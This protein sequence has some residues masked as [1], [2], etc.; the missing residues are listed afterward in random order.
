MVAAFGVL[1]AAQAPTK[2]DPA[3]LKEFLT[4]L[5]ELGLPETAGAKWVQASF[6]DMAAP[7][8]LPSPEGR[9]GKGGN[10]W[11]VREEADG[12]V[13]LIVNQARRVRAVKSAGNVPS[14]G[15]KV[16]TIAE[17]N[18]EADLAA[19]EA[20]L[21][22]PEHRAPVDPSD[23][24]ARGGYEASARI[25]AAS[26]GLLLLAHLQR[27]GKAEQIA[28]LLPKL[29]ETHAAPE[30]VLDGAISTLAE[31]Q[32][33]ALNDAWVA[34]KTPD[35]Y[36][37]GLEALA[38]KFHRGWP[39][40]EGVLLLARRVREVRP[41]AAKSDAA[42]LL[43]SLTAEEVEALPRVENWLLP[44]DDP[45]AAAHLTFRGRHGFR[46]GPPQ[47]ATPEESPADARLAPF[48]ARK[49]EAASALA[50]L[51]A[52]GRY[53]RVLRP[54]ESAGPRFYSHND[55]PEEQARDCYDKMARP[56]E[57]AELVREVLTPVL[58][59]PLL[60]QD[61]LGKVEPQPAREWLKSLA[62]KS[63]EEIAWAYVGN[64]DA[65]D[66]TFL[67]A[68]AFLAGHSAEPALPRV[69]EI[70][71]DDAVWESND[72]EALA[73]IAKKL[74][75]RLGGEGAAFTGQ[76]LA[77]LEAIY[78]EK[79]KEG[80]PDDAESQKYAVAAARRQWKAIEQQ[81]RPRSLAELAAEIAAAPEEELGSTAQTLEQA[82][83][84]ATPE[85][86]ERAIYAAAAV[87]KSAAAKQHLLMAL[88]S[89]MSVSADS[90]RASAALPPFEP[91]T[92]AA[93]R[94]LLQ[95][96]SPLHLD[97]YSTERIVVQ[98]FATATVLAV[99]LSGPAE[100]DFY[101]LV[102]RA[103]R[104]AEAWGKRAVEALITGE[105]LPPLPT[106]ANIP[107]TQTTALR[108]RLA[109]LPAAQVLGAFESEPP[110]HQLALIDELAATQ[111][112]EQA[113]IDVQM[114]VREVVVPEGAPPELAKEKLLGRKVDAALR[115]A[116]AAAVI[117]AG[118]RKENWS[119]SASCPHPLAGV[120][121]TIQQPSGSSDERGITPDA[122]GL[123]AMP[124]P[125]ALVETTVQRR[126]ERGIARVHA[127][128]PIWTDP[129]LNDKW[130]EAHPGVLAAVEGK[131]AEFSGEP[132]ETAP[133]AQDNPAAVREF[134]AKLDRAEPAIVKGFAVIYTSSRAEK[135][136]AALEP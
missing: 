5:V 115:K 40:R 76:L 12:T 51:L 63:D 114:T 56:Y 4:L 108:Q 49:V 78:K 126:L 39:E 20:A 18:L 26:R 106:G 24:F 37:A 101:Q 80:D 38:Q 62:G 99:R 103:K 96:D 118:L 42:A 74:A 83:Q 86:A 2:A 8:G 85:E 89:R 81:L 14:R 71:L 29:M 35:T 109:A 46:G 79:E 61:D 110:A 92:R 53:L 84:Q 127:P 82:M 91:P 75:S 87:A 10:A 27:Q 72:V 57:L 28:R 113:F 135:P 77:K 124:P 122:R 68:L 33:A 69:R 48:F 102:F 44:L 90:S 25:L 45:D 70:L 3:A 129:A 133:N 94:A 121:V 131:G 125:D 47:R 50:E 1:G 31:A 7:G 107:K 105:P 123:A 116:F 112:W 66:P 136:P 88:L 119:V 30:R 104:L 6:T 41:E 19:M 58:P 111:T 100:N 15:R 98:D 55:S 64:G 22:Q 21:S 9:T 97:R 43:L 128:L 95:D 36:A 17:A 65:D 11:L 59:Q 23:P 13:E 73:G 54:E 34:G 120:T 93:L 132:P 117:Q 32:L 60:E 134:F 67:N 52:D 16:V 130:R